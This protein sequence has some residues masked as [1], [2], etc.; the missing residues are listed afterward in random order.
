MFNDISNING[1]EFF[2]H[3]THRGGL[4]I[5]FILPGAFENK[6]PYHNKLSFQEF[7]GIRE[8]IESGTD[9]DNNYRPYIKKIIASQNTSNNNSFVDYSC[10]N[11][12]PATKFIVD[13]EGHYGHWHLDI[14]ESNTLQKTSRN[15]QQSSM[16]PHQVVLTK[17]AN[18]K[19]IAGFSI[20]FP[21]ERTAAIYSLLLI[22]PGKR[23][24]PNDNPQLFTK[25]NGIEV[26]EDIVVDGKTF[27]YQLIPK[28]ENKIVVTFPKGDEIP[29]D[30]LREYKVRVSKFYGPSI[31]YGDEKFPNALSCSF[32]DISLDFQK[33]TCAS[34]LAS[35]SS[36]EKNNSSGQSCDVN[37]PPIIFERVNK[38]VD[39]RHFSYFIESGKSLSDDFFLSENNNS[40]MSTDINDINES[41]RICGDSTSF[42]GKNIS[43]RNKAILN[44]ITINGSETGQIYISDQA[45]IQNT[46][47]TSNGGFIDIHGSSR[48]KGK[49]E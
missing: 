4:D 5:D 29:L 12:I 19:G 1:G 25:E 13:K 17:R 43:I 16:A 3:D 15:K 26:A 41:V 39:G 8:F 38:E 7:E 11:G 28:V 46:K 47:I 20:K 34:C 9:M 44:N 10:I 30:T 37:P 35:D 18:G 45:L 6:E 42:T 32:R 22:K 36:E 48:I 49:R 33:A 31:S 27:R 21:Q 23:I 14:A 2:P 24:F 40:I